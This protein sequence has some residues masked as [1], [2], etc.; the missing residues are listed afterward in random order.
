MKVRTS[1]QVTKSVWHALFMREV[2]TRL[3]TDRAGGFWMFAEPIL[4]VVVMVG[5]R[6]YMRAIESIAGA[7]MV[8]WLVIGL[9]A[10][11]MFRDGLMRGLTSIESAQAL[12]SYRQVKPIDT[13]LVR[14]FAEGFVR[15]LVLII[16]LLGLAL[17]GFDV[18]PH[19]P[20]GFAFAWFTIWLF[21]LSAGLLFSVLGSLVPEVK[22]LIGV[23]MLPLLILSA[24]MI[25][26]QYLPHAAQQLL[27]YNPIAHALE[28]ARLSFFKGYWT[29]PGIDYVYLYSWILSFLLLGLMLQIRFEMKLKTR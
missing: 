4:F 11:F 19:N 14:I 3:W 1:W 24:V 17:L 18:I 6:A 7:P 5:I 23:M 29:L 13:V 27:M 20:I 9:V 15:T 2:L 10:F 26:I 22:K 16:L 28:L 25:P 21:G 8:T 12:F